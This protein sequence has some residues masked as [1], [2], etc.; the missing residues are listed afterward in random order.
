M[1]LFYYI[2]WRAQMKN[3]LSICGCSALMQRSLSPELHQ[4]RKAFATSRRK[5]P[6]AVRIKGKQYV[7][8]KAVCTFRA[9]YDGPNVDLGPPRSRRKTSAGCARFKPT[10]LQTLPALLAGAA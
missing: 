8:S 1:V 10:M 7:D 3:L 2:V 5:F 6:S 4:K 9:V